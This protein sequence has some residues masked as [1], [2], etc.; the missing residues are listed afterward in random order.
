[1]PEEKL[2]QRF[3]KNAASWAG[4]SLAAVRC[5]FI[6]F[7]RIS[8]F[9]NCPVVGFAAGSNAD[10]LFIRQKGLLAGMTDEVLSFYQEKSD[11]LYGLDHT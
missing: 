5:A 1:L 8:F 10:E 4:Q 3:W 9:P 7:C 2:L 6:D 11:L